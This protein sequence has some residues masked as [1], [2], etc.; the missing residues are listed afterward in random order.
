MMRGYSLRAI[1]EGENPDW[2]DFVVAHATGGGKMLRSNK[3]KL[4]TY[5]GD[6]VIQLFDME[7]DP[8]ETRNLAET[9]DTRALT[10]EMQASLTAFESEFELAGT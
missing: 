4:I 7:A 6:P 2:R 1:A 9:P 5:E 3:H 10:S 8:W